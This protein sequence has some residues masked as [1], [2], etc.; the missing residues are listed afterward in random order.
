MDVEV[1]LGWLSGGLENEGLRSLHFLV[2]FSG[3]RRDVSK[4]QF[5]KIRVLQELSLE[6][7]F[8]KSF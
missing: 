6:N 2:R 3:G 8:L 1:V 5:F 7:F 4:N